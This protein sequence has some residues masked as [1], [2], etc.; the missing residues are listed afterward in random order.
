[1]EQISSALTVYPYCLSRRK[2][3]TE[4]SS[5]VLFK[6]PHSHASCGDCVKMEILIGR[7]GW[8]P[9]ICISKKLTDDANAA[10]PLTTL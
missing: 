1:M 2:F 10:A 7:S 3:H 8:G 6:L 9:I 5:T 4:K